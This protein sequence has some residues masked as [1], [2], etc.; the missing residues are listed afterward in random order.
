MILL[1]S[2]SARTPE[3][4]QPPKWCSATTLLVL[5]ESTG[6]PLEPPMLEAL[7]KYGK[8]DKSAAVFVQSFEPESLR[9][10]R[11]QTTLRL[12]QLLD[13]PADVSPARLAE[14]AA[15]AVRNQLVE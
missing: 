9:L 7:A 6:L 10:L 8:Q 4:G 15:Y 14:I 13:A 11:P 3:F 5:R 12:I 1:K 2:R